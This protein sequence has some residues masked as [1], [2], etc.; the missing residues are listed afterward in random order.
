MNRDYSVYLQDI[1]ES[2]SAIEEYT[3]NISEAKFQDD[4]KV[5]D[6]V[7]RRL[8]IIGEAVKNL[9][10]EFRSLYP[11]VPWKQIA[12]MRDILI[13]EY[14]GVNPL[15]VWEA[16]IKDIPPLKQNILSIVKK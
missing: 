4:H 7:I 5:Q 16:I 9:D 6:A 1:L 11:Q 2:I 10:D 14:F 12:G 3:N 13:H 8:E 15:R